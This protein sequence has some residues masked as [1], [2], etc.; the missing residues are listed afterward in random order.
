MREG[1]LE[2]RGEESA[3]DDLTALE[4]QFGFGAHEEGADLDHPRC[5]GKAHA[6]APG[7]AEGAQEV[8][9]GKRMRGRKIDDAGKILR[10]DKE[11]DG[12]DEVHFMDPGDELIA[13]EIGA[14]EAVTDE[15]EEDVEDSIRVWTEGHGAAQGELAGARGWSGEEGLLPCFGDGDGEVP[16]VGRAGLVAAEFASGFVHW[17]VEGVAIDSGSAGVEP[18]GGRMVEGGDDLVEDL[19]G[20][21]AG[22]EDGAAVRGVVAAVD[23]AACEIDADVAVLEFCDP[24]AAGQAIPENDAPRSWMEVAA[25]D[26]NGVAVGV[27]VSGEDLTYLP[28]TAGDDDLHALGLSLCR[29]S[30]A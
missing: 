1:E 23:T 16:G 2:A 8:A 30:V 13:G 15:V 6:S 11:F 18:D 27:K 29:R 10:G 7:V 14:A 25:E 20:K 28:G 22:V 21:H 9:I 26:G 12:A 17:A 19:R 3:W 24:G 4:N 5:S